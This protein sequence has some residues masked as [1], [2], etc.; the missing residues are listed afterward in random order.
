VL[1]RPAKPWLGI[2]PALRARRRQYAGFL[3]HLG[4]VCLAVGVTGTS[5]GTR[6]NEVA[7]HEGETV[8]WAGRQV[9]YAGLVERKA[10]KKHVVEARLEVTPQGGSPY[11]LHPAQH[12]HAPQNEW[13]TEVAIHSTWRGDFYTILHYGESEAGVHLTFVEAP[14]IRW[15]W[16]SGWVAA[17]G[18]VLRLWPV[19]SPRPTPPSQASPPAPHS[20]RAG[21]R[22]TVCATGHESGGP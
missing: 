21:R 3:I 18:V 20:R 6:R 11:T 9:R 4:L 10:G 17:L 12:L 19:R 2:L 16:L 7:M 22:R 13:T 8:A 14:M 1:Q 15:L 5:L